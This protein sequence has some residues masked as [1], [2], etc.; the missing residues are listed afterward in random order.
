M[1]VKYIQD[2]NVEMCDRLREYLKDHLKKKMNV[3]I[4]GDD[5]GNI[6]YFLIYLYVLLIVDK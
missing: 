6:N 1:I 5:K 2:S 4:I 3:E